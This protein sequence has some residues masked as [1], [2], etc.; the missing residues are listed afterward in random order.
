MSW[1][2]KKSSALLCIAEGVHRRH[3]KVTDL[4][5]FGSY[6]MPCI[7]HPRLSLCDLLSVFGGRCALLGFIMQVSASSKQCSF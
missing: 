5:R 1:L 2:G 6:R 4:V 7:F 3:L